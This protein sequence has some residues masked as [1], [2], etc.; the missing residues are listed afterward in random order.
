MSHHPTV[1]EDLQIRELKSAGIYPHPKGS[2][3]RLYLVY[4]GPEAGGIRGTALPFPDSDSA[5][6]WVSHHFPG[7]TLTDNRS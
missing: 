6:A 7:I 4:P 2:G 5:T 3:V 1:V